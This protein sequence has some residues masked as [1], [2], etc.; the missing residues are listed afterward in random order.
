MLQFPNKVHLRM[1][2]FG[3]KISNDEKLN[4]NVIKVK[5]DRLGL[6][7]CQCYVRNVSTL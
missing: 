5:F 4:K 6:N 2:Y 1:H 7:S 3:V